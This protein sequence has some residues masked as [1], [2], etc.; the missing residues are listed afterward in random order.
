MLFCDPA[1]VNSVW[2]VVARATALNELGIAAKVAPREGEEDRRKLRLICVYLGLIN[3][4]DSPIYYKCGKVTARSCKSM[5]IS[6]SDAYTYLQIS[7]GNKYNI[8]ASLYNSADVLKPEK[9][10]SKH[11]KLGGFLNKKKKEEGDYS[12]RE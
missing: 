3:L 11:Q 10:I 12:Q 1:E 8:K 7:S 5:L 6:C 2:E 4:K 9:D